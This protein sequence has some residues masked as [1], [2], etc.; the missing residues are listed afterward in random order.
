MVCIISYQNNLILILINKGRKVKE[1]DSYQSGEFAF[2]DGFTSIDEDTID[3][4]DT[5]NSATSKA[6][7]AD[8][9]DTFV[10]TYNPLSIISSMAQ[11][12][13]AP[14][15]DLLRKPPDV[16]VASQVDITKLH[17]QQGRTA[18]WWVCLANMKLYFYQSFGDS[19]ARYVSDLSHANVYAG[20]NITNNYFA[21]IVHADKRIWTL[22]FTSPFFAQKFE[23]ATMETK[24]FWDTGYSKYFRTISKF[25]KINW[26]G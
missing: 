1:T 14:P 24:K 2:T 18:H 10:L 25:K 26:K 12:V 11:S 20:K 5:T 15:V 4:L 3:N 9:E 17:S 8:S 22:E 7:K 13:V 19:R 21:T 23:F 16:Y 6:A